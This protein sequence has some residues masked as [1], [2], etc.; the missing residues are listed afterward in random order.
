MFRS[1]T[2]LKKLKNTVTKQLIYRIGIL[3]E[4]RVLSD[5]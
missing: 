4:I 2:A 1:T 3:P 5:M